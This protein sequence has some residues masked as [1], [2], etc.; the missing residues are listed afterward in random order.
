MCQMLAPAVGLLL[1]GDGAASRGDVVGARGPAVAAAGSA[2]SP[3]LM[4]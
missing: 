2:D 3:S 1:A 4:S